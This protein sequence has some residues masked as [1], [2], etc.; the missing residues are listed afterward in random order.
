MLIN[1]RYKYP[2]WYIRLTYFIQRI[3]VLITPQSISYRYPASH[4]I[5][6][7][8]K[9]GATMAVSA[10]ARTTTS[11]HPQTCISH[12]RRRRASS[13]SPAGARMSW[14]PRKRDANL[15]WRRWR[16]GHGEVKLLAVRLAACVQ[17]KIQE[18]H[19]KYNA[20]T[21]PT[22]GKNRKPKHIEQDKR[23]WHKLLYWHNTSPA[24]IGIKRRKYGVP[25]PH[26]PGHEDEGSSKA[27]CFIQL[28]H[29]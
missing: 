6:S 22:Q 19:R 23:G 8:N 16:S 26:H 2:K 14:A 9:L 3:S 10:T 17:S 28:Q 4:Q 27:A 25:I 29:G 11:L 1:S 21:R 24:K 18:H 13:P 7:P 12:W 20:R 5:Q 15:P